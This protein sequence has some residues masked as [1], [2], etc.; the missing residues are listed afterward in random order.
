MNILQTANIIML[1]L[2]ALKPRI[3]HS[4]TGSCYIHLTGLKVKSIR[5]ADH[6]GQK[7]KPKTWQLRKD[8][9]SSRK[10]SNRVYNDASRLLNDLKLIVDSSSKDL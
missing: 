9:S 8:I 7:V 5:I 1:E 10:G 6:T 3:V 4:K 2:Q